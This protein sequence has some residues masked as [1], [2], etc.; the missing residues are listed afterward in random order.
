MC[1]QPNKFT[2]L[3]NRGT[4]VPICTVSTVSSCVCKY[5]HVFVFCVK[6]STSFLNCLVFIICDYKIT[7]NSF[8]QIMRHQSTK[9]AIESY[10]NKPI[11]VQ[12]TADNQPRDN[13]GR[14]VVVGSCYICNKQPIR[15]RRKTNAAFN[16]KSQSA[17]SILPKLLNA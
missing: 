14:K 7:D 17:M 11:T 9:L 4:R 1:N 5:F 16:A 3:A 8:N 13:T 6:F 15:K 2:L 10:F 12:F